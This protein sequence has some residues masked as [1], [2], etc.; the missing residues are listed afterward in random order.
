MKKTAFLLIAITA[1]VISTGNASAGSNGNAPQEGQ[2]WI[3]TQDTHVWDED[4]S[5]K[6]IVVNFGKTLKLEN[7]SLSSKG[8]IEIRGETRWINSTVFHEQDSHGDNISLYSTQ[9]IINSEVTLDSIQ[10]NSEV[11]ANCLDLNKNSVLIVTDFDLDPTTT[12]D[13]STIKSNVIGKGNYTERLDYTVQVGRLT[14]NEAGPGITDTKVIVENSDFEYV[15]A[16]RFT[17]DGSYIT[18]STFDMIGIISAYTNDF[19]FIN[20]TIYNSYIFYDLFV[21]GD[22]L[23][24]TID[25]RSQYFSAAHVNTLSLIHI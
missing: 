10:K 17:G 25:D 21:S 13:R 9:A 7:V 3:I 4:V 5:V 2:D 20:N 1:I 12:N 6:D 18:N 23:A 19:R 24:I 11:T 8:F 15:K 14:N 16:L 22:N